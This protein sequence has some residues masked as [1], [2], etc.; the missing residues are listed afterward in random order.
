MQGQVSKDL[1]L[2]SYNI[3]IGKGMDNQVDLSRI[4]KVINHVKPDII[5]IQEVDSMNSRTM[6]HQTEELA[7]MTDM[8]GVFAPA[9]PL[10]KGGKYGI[11]LLSKEKSISIKNISLPGTE[12]KRILLIAE[13]NNCVFVNTHFSLTE[14]DQLT[15]VDIILNEVK[16]FSDK[17]VFFCGDLNAQPDSETILKLKN[18]FSV[19]S[20][21]KTF[22]FPSDKPEICIDYIMLYKNE[23]SNWIVKSFDFV[24]N[25]PLAS[26]HLPIV[27][28]AKIFDQK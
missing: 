17:P 22:T 24:Y 15:S 13:F 28:G 9:I 10:G 5:G 27:V 12:E 19:L 6:F 4:A 8:H 14:K 18:N 3:K 21:F 23:A 1:T 26:D 2:M 20:D 16:R 11:A 25:E 7:K